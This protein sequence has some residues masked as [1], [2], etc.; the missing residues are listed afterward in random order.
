[1]KEGRKNIL[2]LAS[3][4]PNEGEPLSG[5]FIERHAC[6]ASLLNNIH[7]LFVVKGKPRIEK[8]EY[9]EGAKA[10][11]LYY[12]AGNAFTSA[13]KYMYYFRKFIKEYIAVNGKPDLVHV[14]IS[15]RA[16]LA[17]LY[18]KWR[19]KLNY[20]ITEHWTVFCNEAKPNFND[21]S[22]LTRW[23]IKLI[24]RNALRTSVVSDYLGDALVRR[25]GI[26]TPFR[27]PNV[28]DTKLFYPSADRSPVFRFIHISLLNYQKSPD[29]IFAAVKQLTEL[30]A[31]SF[32]LVIY[33][34]IKETHINR[35][36]ELQ[37]QNIIQFR[38]EVTHNMLSEELRK[39]HALILYSRYET[40]GCVIIEA[41]ASGVPVI[42]SDI[43]VMHENVDETTGVF[44]ETE[45]PGKLTEKMLWMMDNYQSF[46]SNHLATVAEEKYGFLTVA[47]LF[48]ELYQ[49]PD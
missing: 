32:E 7:V 15:Y 33:G 42:V 24:Y 31:T 10:T 16:G 41:Y 46:D 21:K 30:T 35:I 20:V 29:E 36:Q 2:W 49:A 5:D 47:R 8:R 4:F 3:W 17:A 48:D 12:N 6:A 45:N 44:A 9:P 19:L 28:V 23:L 26:K 39:S 34:P 37:L 1:M 38:G 27:I 22:F 40:F 25:F 11:L 14:H 43:P 18:C 13:L